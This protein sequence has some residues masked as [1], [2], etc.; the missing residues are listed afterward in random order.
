[1]PPEKPTYNYI[2]L[3]GIIRVSDFQKVREID[4]TIKRQYNLYTS[5]QLASAFNM[6]DRRLA[7]LNALKK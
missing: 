3:Q 6:I 1:M 5:D 7:E 2:Y 4:A